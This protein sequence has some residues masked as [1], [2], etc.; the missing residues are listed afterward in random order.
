MDEHKRRIIEFL[1]TE[2]CEGK[3]LEIKEIGDEDPLVESGIL[4]SLG[5]LKLMSFLD[6]E[7]EIDISANEIKPGNFVNLRTICALIGKETV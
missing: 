7:L 2:I 4:D 5:I 6:E 3:G 1:L